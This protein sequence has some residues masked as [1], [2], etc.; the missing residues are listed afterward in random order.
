MTITL[1]IATDVDLA[2]INARYA[3][4]GFVPSLPGE[5][6][7]IATRDGITAGQGRI[8]PIDTRSGELGGIHVLP[9]FE[10]RGVAR[11]IVAFLIQQANLPVL[12]CL[13]FGELEGF[14]G[15]MGFV[16]V[17]EPGCVPEKVAQKHQWC[18]TNYEKP[19]LL[20]ERVA[21]S[22]PLAAAAVAAAE[23]G[24]TARGMQH[25]IAAGNDL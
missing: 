20:L 21:A 19:V 13:P 3:G 22:I 15:S 7:V 5:L 24:A 14:Y 2:A 6:I 4:I 10:G 25:Q 1:R 11:C 16:P 12:Y 9:Q 23:V 18:N 17:K 8:V